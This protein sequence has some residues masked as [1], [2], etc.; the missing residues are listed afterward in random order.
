M[1]RDVI[2]AHPQL[3][4]SVTQASPGTF[5]Q[6]SGT[7]VQFGSH[8]GD[9]NDRWSPDLPVDGVTYSIDSVSFVKNNTNDTFENLWV[10]VYGSYS[11]GADNEALTV[12]DFRGA[13]T[14]SVAFGA[15]GAGDI[16]TWT[17]ENVSLQAGD[18]QSLVFLFQTSAD[19]MTSKMNFADGQIAVQRTT[20]NGGTVS[21]SW[22]IS[23]GTANQIRTGQSLIMDLDISVIPE[24][25]TYA[26]IVGLAV[27]G[28]ALIRRRSRKG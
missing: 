7:I 5:G 6:T 11:G 19:E 4:Y 1:R 25:S 20:S 12:G 10:G 27:L 3:S 23:G 18:G 22:I 16:L 13:S 8:S 14:N 24:P 21:G 15:A 28:V 9:I 2:V 26:A 17:F